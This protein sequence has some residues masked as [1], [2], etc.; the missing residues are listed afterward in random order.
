MGVEAPP[1][2]RCSGALIGSSNLF[3]RAVAVT[4]S[5]FGLQSGTALATVWGFW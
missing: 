3:E 2:Y 4:I 1:H 5:L